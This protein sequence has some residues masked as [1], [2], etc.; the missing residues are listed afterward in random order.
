[1]V[2]PFAMAS[3]LAT[4]VAI[5]TALFVAVAIA[6]LPGSSGGR[7]PMAAAAQQHNNQHNSQQDSQ[8]GGGLIEWRER[9][10][11]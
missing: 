4:L 10:Y 5:A 9:N 2:E 6:R 1:M 3:S 7:V 8:H 11:V